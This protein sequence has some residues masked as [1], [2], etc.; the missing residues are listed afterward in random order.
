M[1]FIVSLV[2]WHCLVNIFQLYFWHHTH[3]TWRIHVHAH[4]FVP[5]VDKDFEHAISTSLVQESWRDSVI[6][7]MIVVDI[8]SLHWLPKTMKISLSILLV[9]NRHLGL[10]VFINMH[11]RSRNQSAKNISRKWWSTGERGLRSLRGPVSMIKC[12]RYLHGLPRNILPTC[13]GRVDIANTVCVACDHLYP[14]LNRIRS[15]WTV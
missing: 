4:I 11:F 10:L 7:I 8:L 2:S 3:E 6:V 5:S 12:A 15:G 13:D 1:V 14:I 9:G